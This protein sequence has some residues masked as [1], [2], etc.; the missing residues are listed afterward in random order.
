MTEPVSLY[1]VDPSC[2]AGRRSAVQMLESVL[3]QLRAT[4]QTGAL[5]AVLVLGWVDG[6]GLLVQPYAAGVDLISAAGLLELG[7]LELYAGTE[8]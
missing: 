1:A 6:S 7:K 4:P 8:P 2:D 3:A 5:R